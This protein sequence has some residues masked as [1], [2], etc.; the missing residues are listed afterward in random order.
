MAVGIDGIFIETHPDPAKA[1][2]DSE[3]QQPQRELEELLR[4]L[5]KFR[6]IS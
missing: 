1:K 2:S 5:L 6:L 4:S 3:S